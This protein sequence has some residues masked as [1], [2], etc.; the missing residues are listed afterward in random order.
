[1]PRHARVVVPQMPLHIV[2]RGNNR[3]DCFADDGDRLVYLRLL[4]DGLSRF[5]CALHAYCLMT[6]H[7]HLLV[8]PPSV[9]AA[10]G[11]MHVVSQRYAQYFNR[12]NGR[13]GTLWEGRFRSSLIASPSY[14]IA[15]YRYIEC[16]PVRAGLAPHP[17]VYRWSSHRANA[18]VACDPIL[19]PHEEWA[20]LGAR[21]YRQLFATELDANALQRI[22]ESLN[23]GFPLGFEEEVMPLLPG[24]RIAPGR[25][26][27]PRRKMRTCPGFWD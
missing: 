2:Q 6:N 23:G 17:V 7:V 20:A 21:A 4:G 14:L 13:T 12:K 25:P 5:G 15:C 3:M 22:R 26:G 9:E 16:N 8:T 27:R 10:A 11:L 1:M 18:G 19:A 24:L